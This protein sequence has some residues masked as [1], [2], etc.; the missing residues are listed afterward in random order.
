MLI[1]IMILLR[2]WMNLPVWTVWTFISLW[3][4]KDAILYF[5]VWRAYDPGSLN[6][7]I[8]SKCVTAD[9]LSPS[10][11][12]RIRGELWRAKVIEGSSDIEKGEVVTVKGMDGLTLIVQSD[13]KEEE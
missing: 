8:G 4:I 5:F 2:K 13:I 11:N 12:V 10:G 9:R 1:M 6:S 7:M 3:V